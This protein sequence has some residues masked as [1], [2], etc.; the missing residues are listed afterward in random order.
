MSAGDQA[1]GAAVEGG[2]RGGAHALRGGGGGGAGPLRGGGRGGGH[3][4]RG[5]GGGEAEGGGGAAGG[6]AAPRAVTKEGQDGGAV[7]QRG[8]ARADGQPAPRPAKVRRDQAAGADVE[9]RRGRGAH[10]LR[11]GGRRRR[12]ALCVGLQGGGC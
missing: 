4:C 2:D 7:L 12:R 5:A 8:V 6:K 9:G 1:A 11:G 10:S 3:R